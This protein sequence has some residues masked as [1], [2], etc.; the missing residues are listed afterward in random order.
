MAKNSYLWLK[1][2]EIVEVLCV[3][4]NPTIHKHSPMMWLIAGLIVLTLGIVPTNGMAEEES[5]ITEVV[6]KNVLST[7]PILD[8]FTWFNIEYERR[9]K[10]NGTIGLAASF[11]DLEGD[12]EFMS[13]NAFY[14]FYPQDRAP[15]GFFFGGR[16]GVYNVEDGNDSESAFGFGID[17][18]YS[19]LLGKRR[20]FAVSLGIGA[21]R[22]F[23]G[24]L[25]T[26]TTLPT[27]RLINIGFAF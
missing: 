10:P 12:E 3:K 16:F 11:I 21:I 4:K 18:A 7:N 6:N 5:E 15:S 23:G 17:I 13:V 25:D 26:A 2:R 1:R 8:L 19:W 20:N 22:L 14:R 24:D 9:I 27:L